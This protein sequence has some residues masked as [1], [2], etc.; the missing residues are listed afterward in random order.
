MA[1]RPEYW[2]WYGMLHRCYN[3]AATGFKNYGGRGIKVCKR[4]HKFAN[5][6]ADMGERPTNLTLERI[7]NS[8]GYSPANCRWATRK[9]QTANKRSHGWNKLTE[10]DAVTIRADP[11][12]YGEIAKDY[13][14]TRPMIGYIKQGKSFAGVG[15]LS[16]TRL[17]GKIKLTA[18][19]ARAIRA[20]PRR[21]YRVIA[22]DYG[23][24]RE[25]IK[26]IMLRTTWSNV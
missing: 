10:A 5:F 19:Q 16:V 20:D 22:A 1:Q 23:V 24:S 12:K 6:L 17:G 26:A 11:R 14:V 4:W 18:D 9:E 13:G 7:N 21:P 3:P 2:V 15:G 25:T 8:R